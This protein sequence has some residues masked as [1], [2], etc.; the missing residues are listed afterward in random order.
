MVFVI[1]KNAFICF[2][3][4]AM[5]LHDCSENFYPPNESHILHVCLF[6]KNFVLYV[7]E[8]SLNI[9]QCNF[10][11]GAGTIVLVA[12]S[13]P[14]Q[15]KLQ[16]ISQLER[17]TGAKIKVLQA[18]LSDPNQMDAM[19]ANDLS[20][21][22]SIAGIVHT[23]MILRDQLIPQVHREDVYQVMAPKVKGSKD[24]LEKQTLCTCKLEI[25]FQSHPMSYSY[26]FSFTIIYYIWSS[27]IQNGVALV[28][29]RFTL[30]IWKVLP[31]QQLVMT[32]QQSSIS[33]HTLPHTIT[34]NK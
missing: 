16:E 8:C 28:K 4:M 21:L 31:L 10:F 32:R 14:S 13:T 26:L 23:A 9:A 24:I 30:G 22:P 29:K 7:W 2:I 18:D 25:T 34:Q 12:R 6:C 15:S 11:V 20:K 5:H 19:Y 33:Y 27:V 17:E 3:P 1:K